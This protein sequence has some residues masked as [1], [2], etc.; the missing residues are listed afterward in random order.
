MPDE[1]SQINQNDIPLGWEAIAAPKSESEATAMR[2]EFRRNGQS[3]CVTPS[4][5]RFIVW[6]EKF[7]VWPP[8]TAHPHFKPTKQQRNQPK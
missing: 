7:Q 8:P 6:A 4:E 5:G 3:A 2:D 1:T